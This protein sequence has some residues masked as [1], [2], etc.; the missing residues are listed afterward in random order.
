M[1]S[2]DTIGGVKTLG[3]SRPGAGTVRLPRGSRIACAVLALAITA[4]AP[5]RATEDG[6]TPIFSD[7][8][9]GDFVVAG[10]STRIFS[11][12]AAQSDPFTVT[13]SGIPVGSTIVAA[14]ANWT[15]LTDLPGEADEAGITIN[16]TSVSGMLAGTGTP[17]LGW[18]KTTTASYTANVTSLITGNGDYSI[19]S[20]V[21]DAVTGAYGEGFS[22]VA[23][24]SNPASPLNHVNVYSGLTSNTS[25]PPEGF[26]SASALYDF[27]AGPY[28]GGLAHFFINALDG[29]VAPDAFMINGMNAGGLLAGTG[30][31][32]DAWQG[33]LGPAADGNFYDHAEGDIAAFLTP[34]DTSLLAESALDGLGGDT[35]GHSFGAIAFAVPEPGSVALVVFGAVALLAARRWRCA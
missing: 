26:A 20:A 4:I 29:Q 23:V 33:L 9:N 18:G 11:A 7:T 24:F 19:G 14:F 32:A 34:G 22:I 28:L 15:Y 2:L 21:D 1:W 16:G 12:P 6:F 30:S 8:L 35:I 31:A 10:S 17:D 25:N 5:C 13:L 27:A 3:R